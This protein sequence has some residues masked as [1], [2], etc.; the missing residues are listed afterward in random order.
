M[1]N[2][3]IQKLT[4]DWWQLL[5]SLFPRVIF[6]NRWRWRLRKLSRTASSIQGCSRSENSQFAM[7]MLNMNSHDFEAF[8]Q[9]FLKTVGAYGSWN[10]HQK[11]FCNFVENWWRLDPK[12]LMKF[13]MNLEKMKG[14]LV[15]FLVNCDYVCISVTIKV[16]YQCINPPLNLKLAK[17]K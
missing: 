12:S 2:N 8:L 7:V 15:R 14:K 17:L 9:Q 5:I 11:E 13:L 1:N 4:L 6:Q 16:K 3:E 10:M